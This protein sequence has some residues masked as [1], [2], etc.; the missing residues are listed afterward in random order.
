MSDP[1]PFPG[2]PPQ[3][4]QFLTDLRANNDRLWFE[5]HRSDFEKYIQTPAKQFANS[6]S[7]ALE[8]IS[9]P[10][11]AHLPVHHSIFRIHRD[12]R[13]SKDK[14]PYK[15]HLG[16]WFWQ[17]NRPK[18]ENSGYYFHLEPSNLRLGIGIYNF[19]KPYLNTSIFSLTSYKSN[20]K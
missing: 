18:M 2:F 9:P 19:A 14:T 6:M 11:H 5:E 1:I 4:V 10:A 17:G 20:S 15:T 16:V 12:L 8:T 13:F 3:S 7:Q